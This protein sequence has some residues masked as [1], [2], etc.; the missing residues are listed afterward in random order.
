[1]KPKLNPKI[2]GMV[3]AADRKTASRWHQTE[4]ELQAS[5]LTILEALGIHSA[6]VSRMDKPTTH[7]VGF[8]DITFC[9]RALYVAFEVKVGKQKLRPAQERWRDKIIQ[10]GGRYYLVRSV[11]EA[12]E[13]IKQLR[14]MFSMK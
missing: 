3:N 6:N 2:L 1:V 12:E 14:E 5:I 10:D 13:I 9:Y 8:P 11:D 4:A 7:A